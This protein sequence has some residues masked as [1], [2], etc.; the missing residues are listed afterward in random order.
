[1]N[2]RFLLGNHSGQKEVAHFLTSDGCSKAG[3]SACVREVRGEGGLCATRRGGT[4]VPWTDYC[5]CTR[6]CA[7]RGSHKSTAMPSAHHPVG[8]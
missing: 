4:S 2:E 3:G 5:M 8:F 1:M 6:A 7:E